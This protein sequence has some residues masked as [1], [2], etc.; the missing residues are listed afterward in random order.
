M[1]EVFKNLEE[2]VK[3]LESIESWNEKIS[4][5]KEIKEK[6][7]IEQ[8]K[9]SELVNMVIKNEVKT[10]V[11]NK[12]KKS[13]YDKQDLDTLVSTFKDAETL[14]EKIKLYHII[15]CHI[16]DVEKQLFSDT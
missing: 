8:Q 6:I 12:K 10:D 13:K 11:D 5:M 15:N 9:L 16:N 2:E 4:K 3:N 1:S 7:S 14:E